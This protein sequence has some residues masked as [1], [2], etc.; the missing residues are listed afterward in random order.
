MFPEHDL[1]QLADFPDHAKLFLI[2]RRKWQCSDLRTR[3]VP[4]RL[5]DEVA[6]VFRRAG[7]HFMQT[8]CVV[9]YRIKKGLDAGSN[10]TLAVA[11]SPSMPAATERWSYNRRD[12]RTTRSNLG[13]VGQIEAH[14][15]R[16]NGRQR[17]DQNPAVEVSHRDAADEFSSAASAFAKSVFV[18]LPIGHPFLKSAI[19]HLFQCRH[20]VAAVHEDQ[21]QYGE[22]QTRGRW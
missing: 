15:A 21:Q 7:G 12:G 6:R 16:P 3:S 11:Y 4:L 19:R 14:S 2:E 9:E 1:R 17:Q 18:L 8:R 5:V 22:N 10:K 13:L 20:H